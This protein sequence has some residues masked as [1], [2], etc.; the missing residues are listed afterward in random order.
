M[1]VFTT[2]VKTWAAEVLSIVDVNT[3]LRDNLQY[4]YDNRVTKIAESIAVGAVAN[5]TFSSIPQ[6]YRNLYIVL[7]ARGD[8][9]ATN[10]QLYVQF[11]G[12]TGNNY[13]SELI[14]GSGSA[15]WA[16]A[17]NVA[18]AQMVLGII[19]A[20]NAPASVAGQTRIDIANYA[21][22]VFQKTALSRTGFKL[23]NS[24]TNVQ[25]GLAA[26]FWRSGAVITSILLKPSAGN[27][28]AGTSAQLYGEM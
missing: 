24:T 6:T 18:F 19:S 2:P 13:D 4:L 26:G 27:F 1:A 23:A 21:A 12:D 11:N 25:T 16:G 8:T 15:A 5:I 7:Q 10:A 22:A 9:A 28:I 3:Y 17:E 20:A 14:D